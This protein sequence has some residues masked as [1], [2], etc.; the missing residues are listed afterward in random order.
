MQKMEKYLE[1]STQ[2]KKRAENWTGED[3]AR[4]FLIENLCLINYVTNLG[5]S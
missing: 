3:K 2:K 1:C 4:Y 5:T